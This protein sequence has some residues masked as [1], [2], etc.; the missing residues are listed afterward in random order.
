MGRTHLSAVTAGSLSKERLQDGLWQV[1][2]RSLDEIKE[3]ME[4]PQ[5]GKDSGFFQDII[6]EMLG[7]LGFTGTRRGYALHAPEL[8]FP[9]MI[10]PG[11][12]QDVEKAAMTYEISD[13]AYQLTYEKGDTVV[14]VMVNHKSLCDLTAGVMHEATIASNSTLGIERPVIP[15]EE[16]QNIDLQENP[17]NAIWEQGCIA[18]MGD[19]YIFSPA[20]IYEL[21]M[22]QDS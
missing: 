18:K 3:A 9:G 5:W 19:N 16:P 2:M 13:F 22:K 6:A 15:L 4:D 21:I 10:F 1:K 20:M 7:R 8:G 11:R 12:L 17:I 14:T